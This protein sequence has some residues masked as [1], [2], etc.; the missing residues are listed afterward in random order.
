MYSSTTA[1]WIS[2][3]PIGF[4]GGLNLYEYV[5]ARPTHFVDPS[6]LQFWYPPLEDHP[7]T[8]TPHP[9]PNPSPELLPPTTSLPPNSPEC[10]MYPVDYMYFGTN[11]RCFCKCA[12]DNPWSNFVRGC[13]RNLYEDGVD[14]DTA[15]G[16]C[17]RVADILFPGLR[18]DS[19]LACCVLQCSPAFSP[20]PI[21]P[22]FPPFR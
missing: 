22:P 19:K 21:L 9:Y 10:D 18:P 4:E 2:Q 3:D 7:I 6:G 12:G 16:R 5:N 17:Y 8:P 13:L 14:P 15:H 11:A 1:R 20:Q